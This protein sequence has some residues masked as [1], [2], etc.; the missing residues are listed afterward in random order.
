M[1]QP[2][3]DDARGIVN[4]AELLRTV[5][6]TRHDPSAALA[7]F[8]GW[9]WVITWDQRGAPAHVQG[10]LP[11]PV[12]NVTFMEREATVTGVQRGRI[13]R[14]L[15]DAG[16][17]I[18][19][20]FRPAGFRPFIDA[21]LHSLTNRA[22]PVGD[23]W[24][25]SARAVAERVGRAGPGEDSRR[26]VDEYLSARAPTAAPPSEEITAIVERVAADRT[27]NR[28][29]RLSAAVG[30]SPRQLQRLFR[31]HVGVSPKW[32]IR[33]YRIYDVAERVRDGASVDWSALAAELDYSDQAHLTRD[34][35]SAYGLP[36]QQYLERCRQESVLS[37]ER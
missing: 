26:L 23:L 5:T 32:V 30:L 31:E 6:F 19:V 13:N 10:V 11:H 14:V 18:G 21:P 24:G 20:R 28:V 17:V 8:V 35:R 37:P 15:E 33:R 2:V 4:P 22:I 29:D 3:E 12:V 25:P 27:I 7:P 9:Y 34:F 16:W 1:V 36:P